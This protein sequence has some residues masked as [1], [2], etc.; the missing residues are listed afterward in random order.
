MSLKPGSTLGKYRIERELGRGGMGVVFL[1]FDPMLERQVAIKVLGAPG[2]PT[3]SPD[4]V[5]QEAR[6]A[7]ALNH[8]N[9]CTV[10]EVGIDDGGSF[11]AMEYI[12][13][14]SVA[15]IARAGALPPQ[16]AVRYGIE[17]A[18]A[19]AHAH[20]R[21]IVHRDLK[22]GNAIISSSGRLKLVDFG[23]ARR[24]DTAPD[25]VTRASL[26][27]AAS[28][29]GTPY[30]MA[31]EQLRAGAVDARVDIW[32]LGVLLHEMLTGTGPFNGSTAAELF[33]A[34]LRDPPAALPP[35]VPEPVREVVQ[36]CLAKDPVQRYQRAADV[37]LVLETIA[38]GLQRRGSHTSDPNVASGASLPPPPIVG[39]VLTAVRLIGRERERAHL[40]EIWTRSKNGR[41]QA[42]LLSG[43][44]GIG[45][46]R[47]A[48]EFAH[49]CAE[50]GATV[51][52]GRSDEEALVPYQPFVEALHWYVHVCPGEDLRE[53]L[54]AI[55]GGGE[56]APLIPQLLRRLPDLPSPTAMSPEAQ[57]YRLFEAVSGLLAAAST[58]RPVVVVLDDLHWAD[59]P[60]LL[61]LK[62]VVRSSAGG[63]LLLVGTYRESE[64]GRTH[65]LAEMLADLR[66]EEAVTR[67]SL[68]GLGEREVQGLIAALAGPE[69]SAQLLHAVFNSTGGN[70]FFVGE[71]VRH[72]NETGA[73]ARTGSAGTSGR[74]TDVGLPEG[75]KEV[76]GRR[77]SRVSEPCNRALS[78]A[79]VIGRDFDLNVLQALADLSENALLDAMDEAVS[80]QLIT[81]VPAVP[82]RF[83]FVHALIRETLYGE[84]TAPRRVRLHRRV[85]EALE[86]LTHGRPNQPLADLAYHFTQAAPSGPVDKAIDYATRA[87]DRAAD[88]MAHEEAARFYEMAL[89]SLEFADASAELDARRL[90]LHTRRARAFG[91][92]AQWAL[93]RTEL[94]HAL[95]YMQPEQAERRCQILLELATA[96]FM[97]FDIPATEQL[98]AE[99]LTLAERLERPVLA[100]DAMALVA[101][102]RQAG[103]D[104]GG[105]IEMHYSARARAGVIQT[106]AF[107]ATHFTLALYLAGR[108][109]E[110]VA[111]AASD[112]EIARSSHAT[113]SV[114]SSLS[115]LGLSL[116]GTGRYGE[117]A[118]VFDDA[119]QFGL[120]HGVLPLLARA[121]AMSCG[122]HLSTFDYEG[123][124]ALQLEAR[125]LARTVNFAP[126][127]VSGGIDF[128]L[129]CARRHE[130]GRAEALLRETETQAGSTAGWHEWLWRLRLCQA[131]AELALARGELDTAVAEATEGIRQSRARGRPKYRDAGPRD[132]R[133]GT[134]RPRPDARRHRRRGRCRAARAPN[135]GSR[136]AARRDRGPAGIGWD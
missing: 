18:D 40:A 48:L 115:H 68:R 55:G 34:I 117:A 129:V 33:S 82:G 46:T 17:A 28:A 96:S 38:S 79:A 58:S 131:R 102:C 4:R 70:P 26:G 24:V 94:Q 31:P 134:A 9:I 108:A 99:T 65:P 103:G 37:R 62:H 85:G 110:A 124:E 87:G 42:L 49:D 81:E 69:T 100:A 106:V 132:T 52:V 2:E 47:L 22:A 21:G 114:M 59:K 57:R 16:D 27:D 53:N 15:E 54:A 51:L 130:P 20:D 6:S 75:I 136:A 120:K 61:M 98:A 8:P 60:T 121:I 74:V 63:S 64:L 77:L 23:L 89:Q 113:Q 112:A 29:A 128:L 119:R 123:A 90:D 5:L 105:A 35:H 45:K 111:I 11:I 66:R 67:L 116:A 86:H 107:G 41:R 25:A 76:I 95:R 97:L 3:G 10:Y 118:R 14:Q 1:G 73:L 104:P 101:G 135:G 93:E 91:A 126:S 80:A 13:G 84:L 39:T 36:R 92:L 127:V 12:D 125:E 72:L 78:L 7:S 71:M 43:E 32:A 122:F 19:L 83:S 44:P 50:E 88:A 30:A 109:T 133:T 56:L